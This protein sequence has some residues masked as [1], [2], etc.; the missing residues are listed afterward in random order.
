[1]TASAP[2]VS[3]VRRSQ[4]TLDAYSGRRSRLK[5]MLGSSLARRPE[6][7]KLGLA[8][9]ATGA[10]MRSVKNRGTRRAE[11]RP[12]ATA[13]TV[14]PLLSSSCFIDSACVKCPRPSP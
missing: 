1:M 7:R 9:V 6:G 13:I 2:H 5:M 4:S 8:K 3:M 14:W 11:L 10:P 12:T